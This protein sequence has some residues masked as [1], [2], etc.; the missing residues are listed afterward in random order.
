MKRDVG[1]ASTRL[2]EEET[3]AP[4]QVEHRKQMADESILGRP[5]SERDREQQ[6]LKQQLFEKYGNINP[7]TSVKE[8]QQPVD[9]DIEDASRLRLG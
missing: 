3:Y 1:Q 6:L 9:M 8:Q 2:R 7:R 5:E 4:R